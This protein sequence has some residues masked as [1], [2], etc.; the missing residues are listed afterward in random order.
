MHIIYLIP[1]SGYVTNLRSDT[2]WGY[3]CWGIKHLWGDVELKIFID[4]YQ[5]DKKPE[6]IISST[7]PFKQHGK[8]RIPYFPNPLVLMPSSNTSEE[9]MDTML[10][11]HRLRKK[12]KSIKYLNLDDFK[13]M[14]HGDIQATDLLDDLQMEYQRKKT[15]GDEYL[16]LPSTIEKATPILLENSMTH[17]T[18]D[19]IRGG[20][21]S[22][23]VEGDS[24]GQ[25]FHADDLYWSDPSS[26]DQTG[27]PNTGLFFLV[28]GNI[29]KVAAV[30]R[31]LRDWGMGAD[32]TTGKGSFD[33]VIEPFD[34][35]E[36]PAQASNALLNLSLFQP[37]EAELQYL[38]GWQYQ[39]ENREGYVG[40]YRQRRMKQPR[41]Y[42][43]EGAVFAKPQQYDNSR[44]MGSIR[45]Q[46]FDAIH[47][48]GHDVWDNGIGFMV[49]LNWKK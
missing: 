14:L 3:I 47:D 48:P 18:I 40:F 49:N 41:L 9:D 22:L 36:P 38:D 6:C 4:S 20:T 8:E 27:T 37:T 13:K 46:T 29:E 25:L 33:F 2:L 35:P 43:S 45:K 42:F 16:P 31:L 21:L 5:V 32:R 44:K 34:M 24:A 17:N 39:L 23:E 10:T 30:L 1:R 12:L 28:E 19:R 7:F 15:M 11:S 26:E